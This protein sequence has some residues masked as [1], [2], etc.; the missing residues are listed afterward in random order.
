[1]EKKGMV[2]RE[3]KDEFEL[4]DG[5]IYPHPIELEEIPSVEEFQEIYDYWRDLLYS[6]FKRKGD[7]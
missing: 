4:S 1:M 2:V 7:A 5:R 3:T 6:K